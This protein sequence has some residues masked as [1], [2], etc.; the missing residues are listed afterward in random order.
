MVGD[1]SVVL[2]TSSRWDKLLGYSC[3]FIDFCFTLN[4]F[5]TLFV[6]IYI[7]LYYLILAKQNYIKFTIILKCTILQFKLLIRIK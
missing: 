2:S 3:T 1:F 7:R 5:L 4:N 6:Y